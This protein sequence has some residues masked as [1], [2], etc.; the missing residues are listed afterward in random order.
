MTPH[1]PQ[2]YP[3]Y[4]DPFQIIR[5]DGYIYIDKTDL[6]YNMTHPIKK[7]VFLSRPRRFGKSLLVT[8]LKAYFEGKKDL[9]KGLAIEKLEKEWIEY[10]VL[11][12]DMYTAKSDSKEE[13]IS[14]LSKKLREYEQIYGR[15]EQDNYLKE[16]FE[17]LIKRAYKQTGKKVVILIDEYDAPILHVINKDSLEDIRE[18]M[19]D[20]FSPLKS[21][22]E[23][24]KFVFL[25][26][27]TKF[28][29]LSIFSELNNIEDI[30]MN[31]KFATI[32]GITEDEMLESLKLGIENL[33]K[34]QGYS[35]SEAVDKLKSQ[36]D[37]YHFTQDSQDIYN[38][39][40]LLNSLSQ[41]E[42]KN[43]WFSTATPTFLIEILRKYN[44]K[45]EGLS[46]L[47]VGT[48]AF[49]VPFE[50]ATS[51]VPLLYQAGYLT[52]KGYNSD[53]K[54]Y[55]IDIP[56]REVEVGLMRSLLIEYVRPYNLIDPDAIARKLHKSFNSGNID[57][58]LEVLQ[59]FLS[60]IP[61][62]NNEY[63][64][65]HFQNILYVIFRLL[66]Q[67]D[68][69]TEVRNAI[70]RMDMVVIT[71]DT[72]YIFELKFDGSAKDAL[73][74]IDIKNYAASFKLSREKIVK[75]GVNFSSETKTISDWEIG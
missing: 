43:Y 62:T 42:I 50:V 34:K 22:V 26:G 16:R 17:E 44:T 57:E 58:A 6:I 54:E 29:Q 27:I 12:F 5:E 11:H 41:E 10:P 30:S 75:V 24:I 28:S 71:L 47:Y 35:Y 67:F 7:Y 19:R 13:L 33:A 38:P 70:G 53:D 66:T 39:Y 64:E 32:C 23:Y 55:L 72:I 40:S 49:D 20:F 45:L 8:T 48:S 52:I 37:G 46:N 36:Y 59:S 60:E 21:L 2:L 61:Y 56:N 69:R 63:N 1:N 4:S 18:V 15:D 74:Q 14:A 73:R 68:I 25:T 3:I 65:G 9:F 51:A 31:N